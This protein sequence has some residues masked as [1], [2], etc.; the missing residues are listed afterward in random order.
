M[1]NKHEN[2][3]AMYRSVKAVCDQSTSVWS[4]F[5]AFADAHSLLTAELI[6]LNALADTGAGSLKG[7]TETKQQQR[8]I[9]A[10]EAV[11]I[12]GALGA[13]AFKTGD[14]TLAD[15]VDFTAAD[16][17]ATRDEKGVS[18]AQTV[19][20]EANARLPHLA[21]Y[22]VTAADLARLQ[23]AITAFRGDISKPRVAKVNRATQNQQIEN[24]IG[25]IDDLLRE[26]MDRL[27]RKFKKTNPEFLSRYEKARLIIDRGSGRGGGPDTPPSEPPPEPPKK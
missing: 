18:R 27:A 2:K 20:D 22:A 14:R 6:T 24:C 7:I 15:K 10:D 3:R 9:M 16:F 11:I 21:D 4:D 26:L 13:F 1:N 17:L 12:A 25:R 5:K 19:Y 23:A 8:Q